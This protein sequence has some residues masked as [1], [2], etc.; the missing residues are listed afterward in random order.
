[1]NRLPANSLGLLDCCKGDSAI[2]LFLE[3]THRSVA[4]G[5]HF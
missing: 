4:C 5:G 2:D 3:P 1:M